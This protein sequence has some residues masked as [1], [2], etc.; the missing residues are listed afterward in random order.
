MFR[1]FFKSMS[2][3]ERKKQKRRG[4]VVAVPTTVL[5]SSATALSTLFS[6]LGGLLL[7][8]EGL[9]AINEA[10]RDVA[11]A[12]GMT[13]ATSLRRYFDEAEQASAAL[14]TFYDMWGN[15][16]TLEE[17]GEL[18]RVHTYAPCRQSRRLSGMGLSFIPSYSDPSYAVMQHLYWDPLTT[19]E[20]IEANFGL[21][22]QFVAPSYRRGEEGCGGG[23]PGS[24]CL[25][26][27]SLNPFDAS[28]V[29]NVYNYTRQYR[30]AEEIPFWEKTKDM[31]LPVYM[32]YSSDGTPY[33]YSE[34]RSVRYR[35]I[36]NHPLLSGAR[37]VSVWVMFYDW[38]AELR[39]LNA[40]GDMMVLDMGQGL[41][42]SVFASTSE[43]FLLC[44]LQEKERSNTLHNS[45]CTPTIRHLP[46]RGMEAAV[47][48]NK[49]AEG[50][51][52]KLGLAGEEHWCLRRIVKLGKSEDQLGEINV[53]WLLATASMNDR[54]LRSLFLFL[55]FILGVMVIDILILLFEVRSIAVPLRSLCT[56]MALIDDMDVDQM[57]LRIEALRGSWIGVRDIINL[58][59]AFK[60]A[61]RALRMYR[62]FLPA[63]CLPE[64]VPDEAS[65]RTDTMSAISNDTRPQTAGGTQ[66]PSPEVQMEKSNNTHRHLLKTAGSVLTIRR[67]QSSH[68]NWTNNSWNGAPTP[69]TEGFPTPTR[70]S[71]SGSEMSFPRTHSQVSSSLPHGV[72]SVSVCIINMTGSLSQ[73]PLMW[74]DHSQR[75]INLLISSSTLTKGQLDGSSGDRFWAS[76]NASRNTPRWSYYAAEFAGKV[77]SGT[78]SR[79]S[80]G[81]ASG[82][83]ICRFQGSVGFRHMVTLGHAISFAFRLERVSRAIDDG[84]H[85]TIVVASTRI[86]SDAACHFLTRWALN[87]VSE[88]DYHGRPVSVWELLDARGTE[89]ENEEW[90]YAMESQLG[91]C[92]GRYNDAVEHC[93][94]GDYNRALEALKID[95]GETEG[96]KI[97]WTRYATSLR[98]AI[99]RAASGDAPSPTT[100]LFLSE[101]GLI[102]PA[103]QPLW[104]HLRSSQPHSK[105]QLRPQDNSKIYGSYAGDS[106][107]S[108]LDSQMTDIALCT[109]T[110][111][112]T[113]GRTVSGIK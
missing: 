108:T 73:V 70:E 60:S 8:F 69:T 31:W 92:W 43:S 95:T 88:K 15:V 66:S 82:Q 106:V 74:E 4:K 86:R 22:Q 1:A 85:R 79:L 2:K 23:H 16:S 103:D 25:S 7:Y 112:R 38:A 26:A 68:T 37:E 104:D 18:V 6:I 98:I 42:G 48:I 12:E 89:N 41:E 93:G 83:A 44:S 78:K 14:N 50:N 20:A 47:K 94:R 61:T 65:A 51:V 105:N 109:S 96:T 107:N 81:V 32:W 45:D 58:T 62:D 80:I 110:S 113:I 19:P 75:L 5:L 71:S 100:A 21:E 17:L 30:G 24:Y 33:Y 84:L 67:G 99:D 13:A 90:M 91:D 64:L 49:T 46:K 72:K 3:E 39:S 101:S 28:P 34:L 76:W 35:S 29:R 40:T 111:V 97:L 63:Y 56:A 11:G 36:E 52:V 59:R 87:L 55:G 27:Y 54:V 77:K 53:V 10:V 9:K 102:P 57:D